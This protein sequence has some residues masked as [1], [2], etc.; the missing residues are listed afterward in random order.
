MGLAWGLALARLATLIQGVLTIEPV[1][2]RENA[3]GEPA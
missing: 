1:I 2:A 3:R